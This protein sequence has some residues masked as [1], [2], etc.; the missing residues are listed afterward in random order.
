LPTPTRRAVLGA[1]AGAPLTSVPF[2]LHAKSAE[3]TLKVAHPLAASHPT[4]LRLQEAAGRIVEDSGGR[5]EL[6]IFP[7]NQLGGEADTLSQVRSGGVEAYVIG[8]LV[9][10]ALVP[11]AALD[12]VGFA[13]KDYSTVWPAVDGR[14]GATIRSALLRA[15]LVPMPRVWDLG[16]R[17]IT[18]SARPVASVGDLAGLKIRV[19]AAAAYTDLFRSLGAAPASIQ[20]G[21]V[22]ASLQT[23]VVDGQENPL[24]L[25]VTSKFFEVQKHCA[26][27]NHVWQGNWVLFNG[28][29]WRSLP[30]PLQDVVEHRLDEAGLAQRA[31]LARLDVSYRAAMSRAGMRIAAVDAPSFRERLSRSGYYERARR[32]FGDAAWTTL[33]EAVGGRLA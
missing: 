10:S 6:R 28:R 2:A 19:P 12:G 15:G 4:H 9:A 7:D 17:E 29:A 1:L 3:F 25:I 8:G 23:H 31:D 13:F 32:K 5:V 33:E 14:L 16:F 20:F 21:E 26:L 24:G 30:G 22:Y 27:S 11:M 18:T